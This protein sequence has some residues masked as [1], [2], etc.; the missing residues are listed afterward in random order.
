MFTYNGKPAERI[1]KLHSGRLV[2]YDA[3]SSGLTPNSQYYGHAFDFIGI[4]II[5][6]VNGVKQNY[7]LNNHK[8]LRAFFKYK[9]PR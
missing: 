9:F 6:S 4:G 1:A 3:A 5:Y 2:E 8:H 7:D